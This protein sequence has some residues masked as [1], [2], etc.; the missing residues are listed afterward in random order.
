MR[1]HNAAENN[2]HHESLRGRTCCQITHEIMF[3]QQ[4]HLRWAPACCEHITELKVAA[5][6]LATYLEQ[7]A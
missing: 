2:A 6:T 5:E 3:L 4:T 1:E 7:R